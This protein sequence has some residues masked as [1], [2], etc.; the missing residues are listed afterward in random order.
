MFYLQTSEGEIVDEIK[1]CYL[2]Y[3]NPIIIEESKKDEIKKNFLVMNL[4]TDL[5]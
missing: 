4:Q 2:Y 3:Y 5:Y 1:S